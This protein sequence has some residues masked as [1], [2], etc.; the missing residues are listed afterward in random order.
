[1]TEYISIRDF[2]E[3]VNYRITEGDS[4]GWSCYG[5]EAYN[6]SSWNG[7][8]NGYSV[9]IVFDTKNQTV[10]EMSACDY[11]HNRA[12]RWIHPDYRQSYLDELN[13][14]DL[15]SDEAWDDVKFVDLEVAS[16]MLD[17]ATAIVDGELYDTR[18]QVPLDMSDEDFL[19]IAKL[20]HERDITINKLVEEVLLEEIRIR[21]FENE[22]GKSKKISN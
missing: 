17:K 10:Y 21:R 14:R 19:L 5:S 7:D 8:H 13:S 4:Y 18:V 9:S 6:M 12:Y 3:T 16:D 20:A 1:M 15:G 22:S 2:M 11:S